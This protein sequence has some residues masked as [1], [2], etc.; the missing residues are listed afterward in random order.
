MEELIR[1]KDIGDQDKNAGYVGLIIK[2]ISIH[3]MR[4]NELNVLITF[5]YEHKQK[6]TADSICNDA[7]K[8]GYYM[9]RDLYN[10]YNEG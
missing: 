3:R 9:F 4:E 1:L 2:K 6:E 5:L 7:A 10:K 8:S